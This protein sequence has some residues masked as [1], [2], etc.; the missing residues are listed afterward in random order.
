MKLKNFM[1][2]SVKGNDF[3]KKTITKCYNRFLNNTPSCTIA[4]TKSMHH[5]KQNNISM[6]NDL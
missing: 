4:S 3:Q 2:F 1:K 5:S 6:K